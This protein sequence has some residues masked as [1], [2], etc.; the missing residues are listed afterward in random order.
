MKRWEVFGNEYDKAFEVIQGGATH[1]FDSFECAIYR[2]APTCAHRR[3]DVIGHGVE[4]GGTIYCFAH[5]AKHAGAPRDRLFGV[6]SVA[7]GLGYAF[8]AVLDVVAS[9]GV[10]GS[11]ALVGDDL[12]ATYGG[13]V[14]YGGVAYLQIRPAEMRMGAMMPAMRAM[15]QP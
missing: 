9:L 13:G 12:R 7:L 4:A 2:L 6:G 5:C 15:A 11:L 8:P 10:R 1:V 3:C 14:Q